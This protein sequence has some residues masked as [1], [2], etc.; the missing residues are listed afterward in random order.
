MSILFRCVAGLLLVTSFLRADAQIS[1][2]VHYTPLHRIVP[3]RNLPRGVHTMSSNNNL[4]LIRFNGRF[5]LAFRTAPTHFPSKRAK[6]YIMSS[7]DMKDW[8]MESEIK[9][10]SDL[11]EPRFLEFKGKLFLYF[12]QGGKSPFVFD[13]IHVYASVYQ[14]DCQW[15]ITQLDMD[16][17]VP[18]RAKEHNGKAW[19]SA[20]YGKGLY[21]ADH[22]ADLR[23]FN[24]DDGIHWQPVDVLPQVAE[25]GAEEGEFEFDKA[26]NLWATVRLEGK[27][28]FI[29][30]AD[31][32]SLGKWKLYPVDDKFDSALMF[33][34][35][36]DIYVISRRNLDGNFAKA[37]LWWPYFFRQKF[38][39]VSYSF[40]SKVTALFKLDKKC[41]A[42]EHVVD[43]PSTGDNSYPA[44]V[45]LT[46]S[47]Y[48][49][50]NYS[51]D[52]NGKSKNWFRGQLGKTYIYQTELL[53]DK[54]KL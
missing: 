13:P 50:L 27:G 4:D 35:D 31:K 1:K 41:M 15:S 24:S 40:S 19:L 51:S 7:A 16:G 21:Q 25:H 44:L 45:T 36:D 22:K 30:Y 32:D 9:M 28:A 33:T 48:M 54:G 52:I 49:M 46:D 3:A 12:F 8:T 34:H 47:T 5:F 6:M 23:L 11:R 37:P 2:S 10:G 14:G 43:F 38:N 39:L 17:F 53:F 18:W 29:A 26:G 20:Y 42:L